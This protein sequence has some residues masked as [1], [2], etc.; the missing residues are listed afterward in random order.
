MNDAATACSTARPSLL[1]DDGSFTPAQAMRRFGPPDLVAELD[2]QIE[3]ETTRLF[4]PPPPPVPRGETA[5]DRQVTAILRR[6]R[7]KE[8]EK[9]R[10]EMD[11]LHSEFAQQDKKLEA[12]WNL[13]LYQAVC[14]SGLARC[15]RTVWQHLKAEG[16]AGRLR[17]S[18]QP[19]DPAAARVILAADRIPYLTVNSPGTLLDP[20]GQL[21]ITINALSPNQPDT[22][23]LE[24]HALWH[25]RIAQ[26]G[27]AVDEGELPPPHNATDAEYHRCIEALHA[28]IQPDDPP[29]NRDTVW[30]RGSMWLARHCNARAYY[31]PVVAAWGDDQHAAK[32]RKR[33]QH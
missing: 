31:D 18:F 8:P 21:A 12:D 15:Q 28:A 11:R 33:G 20:G 9:A 22:L 7:G 4:P 6:Y 25:A 32:R 13:S 17:F 16:A 26:V 19:R 3:I 29:L 1:P 23:W 24:G 2:R 30:E 10:A 5:W 14:I 27:A